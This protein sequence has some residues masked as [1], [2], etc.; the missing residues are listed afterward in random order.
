MKRDELVRMHEFFNERFDSQQTSFNERLDSQRAR[1]DQL[2]QL[3]FSLKS[4]LDFLQ[5]EL[6]VY[7]PYKERR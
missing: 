4:R 5:D 2:E 6:E 7:Q 3:V 1:I